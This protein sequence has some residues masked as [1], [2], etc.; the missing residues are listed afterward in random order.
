MC[1][2]LC[3]WLV[4]LSSMC[5]EFDGRLWARER[6]I[7]D[8]P[9]SANRQSSGRVSFLFL[10]STHTLD[11][12]AIIR[13]FKHPLSHSA[14]KKKNKS[15]FV[16]T[17]TQSF[18][19]F[20]FFQSLNTLCVLVS[21]PCGGSLEVLVSPFEFQSTPLINVPGQHKLYR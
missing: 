7:L 16:A 6:L 2:S 4:C 1:V 20:L 21:F 10:Y 14:K 13:L 11:G 8:N 15:F 18:Y 19:F 17:S 3:V 12:C 9:T 5:C